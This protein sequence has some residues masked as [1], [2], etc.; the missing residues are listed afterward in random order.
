MKKQLK[1]VQEFNEA[2]NLEVNEKP[3]LVNA[4]NSLL[5]VKLM[6]EELDEYASKGIVKHDLVEVSDAIV[7]MQYVLNGLIVKHGLQHCFEELFNEVHNSNMSKLE[8]DKPI[9]REDGK[10]L[11]G[12]NFFEP[13][14]KVILDKYI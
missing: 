10:I 5:G 13:N 3:T 14:L 8:N 7:D 11:K 4:K 2:F 9:Y 12:K 1:Q 6:Q